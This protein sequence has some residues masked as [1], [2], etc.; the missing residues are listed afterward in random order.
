M[1][2]QFILIAVVVAAVAFLGS[3]YV[4]G[5]EKAKEEA[6]PTEAAEFKVEQLVVGPGVENREP[7][8]VAETFPV[9]TEKV[10]CFLKAADIAKDTEV[11]FV[12]FQGEKELRA[13]TLPLKQGPQWRTFSWKNIGGLKGDWKVEL[14]DASGKV[15]KEVKFKVE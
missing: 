6:K 8:G 5:Q 14:K 13:I 1:K 2:K 11:S 9:T 12:W 7:A 15:V 10:Y 4:I 3:S